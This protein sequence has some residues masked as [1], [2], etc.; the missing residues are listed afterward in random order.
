MKGGDFLGAG[1]FTVKL[2]MLNLTTKKEDI[3]QSYLKTMKVSNTNTINS[4]HHSNKISKKDSI[5]N[6]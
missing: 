4:Y 6:Y 2:K 5:L 1:E 3:S